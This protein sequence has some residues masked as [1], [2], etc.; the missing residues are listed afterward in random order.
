MV[1]QSVWIGI[2]IGVFFAGIGIGYGVFQSAQ[3]NFMP[4]TTQQMQQ[5]MNNPGTMTNWMNTMMNDPQLRQQMYDMMLQ[6]QQFM[7][8]MMNDQQF[9][10]QWFGPMM[11]NWTGNSGPMMGQ[12]P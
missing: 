10:Q 6:N 9:Q 8:G 4:M 2:A 12:N 5:M 11:G 7:Q 3:T 1:K